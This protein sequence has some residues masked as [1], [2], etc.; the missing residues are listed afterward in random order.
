[1]GVTP[2]I[3]ISAEQHETI[4]VLLQR[5]LSETTAWVYGSRAKRTSRHNSDLDL[6]VFAEP[7]QHHQVGELREAFEESNL[8]FRVDLFVWDDVPES[9]RDEIIKYHVVLTPPPERKAESNKITFEGS[10]DGWIE[11][12]LADACN[13]IDYGLTASASSRPCG[14]KFLRI[15]DIVNGQVNWN[16]VPHVVPDGD[17]EKYRLR[18][19]DIVLARTGANT[20]ASAYVKVPPPAIFASYLVRLRAS[21][22]FDS[23]FLAYYLKSPSF[24]GYIRGVLGDKSAQPNASAS[25]MAAAPLRAPKKLVEQ[26]AIAHVLGTLDDKIEL[27]QHMNETLEAMAQAIFRSWFVDFDPVRAKAEGRPTGLPP[28]I[29]DLFPDEL[30]KSEI[31]EIP[32]GWEMATIS[33]LAE[34]T[35]G[36]SPPGNTYNDDG[37]GLPFYQG[38]TDFGFRFP[39]IRK[40]CSEPKRLA[41]ADDV[42]LSVRAPVGD[43]NRA[44]NECCI[45]RGLASIRSRVGSSSWIFYR[46]R[47]L[48]ESF[49][50]FN[51]EGT[52]FGSVS[53]KDLKSLTTIK[54]PPKL[55]IE[56]EGLANPIDDSIRV[57]TEEN[58]VLTQLRDTLLP[59]LISGKL[60]IPDVEKFLE[61]ADI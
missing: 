26:R 12:P 15:T 8:P 6:V 31:G 38:S 23:R 37:I 2:P 52:V 59:K 33:D 39:S 11:C 61:E 7:G 44:F 25:T 47:F 20:G 28:E 55:L 21:R 9:F 29:S 4:L 51:S 40:Y 60:R 53:A 50:T 16:T 49:N 36:Q 43:L 57:K 14:P 24:R 19:G 22:Y 34:V 41:R 58:V 48:K 17:V 5:Y 35:M 3:D 56:F 18:D 46:C 42:L 10:S 32:K 30:V 54:P 13:A 45:G 1:M 27:N